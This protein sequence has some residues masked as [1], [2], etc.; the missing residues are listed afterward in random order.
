MITRDWEDVRAGLIAAQ[1]ARTGEAEAE[2]EARIA[3]R[4]ADLRAIAADPGCE[5]L[6]M[7]DAATWHPDGD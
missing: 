5:D 3:R 1:A 4:T 7:A 6:N 2:I